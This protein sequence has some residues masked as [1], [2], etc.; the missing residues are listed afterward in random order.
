[1]EYTVA[2]EDWMN[3]MKHIVAKDRTVG[4]GSNM[5]EFGD[6]PHLICYRDTWFNKE[7]KNET[8]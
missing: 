2:D 1:M 5:M 6:S 8:V 4:W 3:C 7:E